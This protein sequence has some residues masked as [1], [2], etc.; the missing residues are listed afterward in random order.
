MCQPDKHEILMMTPEQRKKS[1]DMDIIL[2][3]YLKALG[4]AS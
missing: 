2:F 1:E 3:S 4:F